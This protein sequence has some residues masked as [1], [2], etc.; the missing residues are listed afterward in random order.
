[1]NTHDMAVVIDVTRDAYSIGDIVDRTLTVG[2][3]I[4]MLEQFDEDT[5]VVLSNDNGYTYGGL[6][7]GAFGEAE[8]NEDDEWE[9][10]G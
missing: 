8:L 3:I 6:N 9:I 1:M 4:N 10:L 7:Y 2:E 5:P